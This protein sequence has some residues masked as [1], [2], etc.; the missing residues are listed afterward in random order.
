M[1]SKIVT[2]QPPG[3]FPGINSFAMAPMTRPMTKTQMIEC[4]LKSIFDEFYR[5]DSSRTRELVSTGFFGTLSA[6]RNG[7]LRCPRRPAVA[8]YH[9]LKFN[10]LRGVDIFAGANFT[11]QPVAGRTVQ[12]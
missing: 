11:H 6:G 10:H 8:P 3:S 7:A 9:R 12:I 4:A 2:M 1:P 5:I